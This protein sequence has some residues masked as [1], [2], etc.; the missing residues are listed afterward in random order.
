MDKMKPRAVVFWPM[1]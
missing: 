1:I